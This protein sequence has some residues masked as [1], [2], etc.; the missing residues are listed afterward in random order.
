MAP[1]AA[2]AASGGG[3]TTQAPADSDHDGAADGVDQCPNETAATRDGCPLA[4]I[5]SLSAKA[6]RRTATVKVTTTRLAM[7]TI[8]VERKKGRR[9][10]RVTRKTARQL[11]Q[12][13][14]AAAARLKRGKH[15]VRVSISSGAG[16]GTSVSKSFRVR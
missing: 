9:W 6:K 15:R 7:V 10:V 1:L 14:D 13:R 16:N 11:R 2:P 5:A 12:P 4:E 3:G 8:T